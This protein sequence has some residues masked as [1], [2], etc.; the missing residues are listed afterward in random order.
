MRRAITAL[1]ILLVLCATAIVDARQKRWY[2]LYDEARQ[3]VQRQEWGP[4]EQKLLEAKKSGPAPGRNVLRYG[5][6][7]DDYFPDYY[8]GIVYLNTNRPKE[9]QTQFQLARTQKINAQDREFQPISSFEARASQEITR[10]ASATP[11]G[12]GGTTP[13]SGGGGT[14][15]ASGGGTPTG[16]AVPTPAQRFD[17]L[18]AQA[19]ESLRQKNYV[20]AR[21]SVTQAIA[22]NVDRGRADA[23]TREIQQAQ[24]IDAL[25]S[26]IQNRDVSASRTALAELQKLAP[27]ANRDAGYTA[28][29]DAIERT[30]RLTDSERTAMRA[31]FAGNYPQT[32]AVLNEVAKA[33]PLSP[34]GYFYRACGLAA[35]AI[36]GPVVDA[37]GLAQARREYAEAL[38]QRQAIAD[39]RRYISP[40]ILQ[41]LGS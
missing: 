22:L 36:R 17:D 7:R 39:D 30:I 21:N 5:M 12:P 28:R 13:A 2:D 33:G 4:A 19:R 9:A 20:A 35:V 6:L 26:A 16:P 40:R 41:A 25:E 32:I 31:F 14:S 27:N 24:T 23:V 29:I 18:L 1:V 10:L 8:L 15:P 38:K 37:K 3:H 11:A 34:R